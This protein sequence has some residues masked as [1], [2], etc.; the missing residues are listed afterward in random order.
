MNNKWKTNNIVTLSNNIK[1]Y[2]E[3]AYKY[4]CERFS[5]I[6][7][8]Y[9]DSL[10]ANI[11]PINV[12]KTLKYDVDGSLGFSTNYTP[13]ELIQIYKNCWKNVLSIK[14]SRKRKTKYNYYTAEWAS[15]DWGKVSGDVIF[16]FPKEK[17]LDEFERIGVKKDYLKI[18]ARL[19]YTIGNFIPVPKKGRGKL[20]ANSLHSYHRSYIGGQQW[21]RFDKYLYDSCFNINDSKYKE[22]YNNFGKYYNELLYN[23]NY[24]HDCIIKNNKIIDLVTLKV[25]DDGKFS[26]LNS[27]E[28]VESY[29]VNICACIIIR[30]NKMKNEMNR[31]INND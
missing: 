30:G 27:K 22:Y 10:D 2:T 29:I 18:L 5:F 8:C 21:E 20:S 6:P 11:N 24:F 28:L 1:E 23:E 26:E 12:V 9:L 25:C 19:C 3:E 14:I 17:L 13:D 31:I 16:S 4:I 15:K 7:A